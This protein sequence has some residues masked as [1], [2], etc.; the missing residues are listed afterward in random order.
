MYPVRR[1]LALLCALLVWN[2]AAGFAAGDSTEAAAESSAIQPPVAPPRHGWFG[3]FLTPYEPKRVPPV[4][5]TNSSRLEALMRAG[6][7]YLSI[8]DAIALTLENNLDIELQRYGEQ[9]AD[10]NLL[11]AQAGGFAAAAAVGVIGGPASVT[12]APASTG[13][14]GLIVLPDTQ[15]GFLVPNLDPAIVSS[16]NWA[17]QT[18]P[19]SS[20]F[21]TGTAALI[22]RQDT[23]NVAV[24]QYF[25]TGTLVSLGL[26]NNSINNN[27]ARAQFEPSTTSSLTLNFTQHLLQGF[28]PAINDRQIRIARNNREVT[29]LTFKGQVIA[30]VTAVMD[31][32][33]DLVS[34]QQV[35]KVQQDAVAADQR[36]YE[37]NQKQVEVGTLAPIEVTRAEAQIAADQQALTVAQTNVLQQETILKNALTRN[38]V[39][40]PV[41]ANA[42]IIPTDRIQV[43]DVEAI[44]PIQDSVA[45]ALSA[46]PELA[47]FRIL[48]QNQEIGIKG[49]RNELLPTLD[50]VASFANS[51]LA[52]TPVPLPASCAATPTSSQ[53]IPPN[54]YFAGGFGSAIG[55]VF[56]RNFPTYSAGFN[57]TIPLRNRAA[58]AD[59]ITGQL[60]LRQ[61]EV[62]LQKMEN[63]VRVEVQ[64]AVIALQQARAQYQAAV[65]ALR[66]QQ[67]TVD[68]EE[69]KLALGASTT[70]NVILTQRDLVTAESNLVA[71]ESAYAKANVE[72][73]RS[74][75]QT[76]NNNDISIDEAFR[77]TVSRPPSQ[78]PDVPPA[79][80]LPH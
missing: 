54:G 17:H 21:V 44:T 67:A 31:L 41:L 2:P 40:S 7:I 10:V 24:Q 78:I 70:Y 25:P 34:Y 33:W 1:Y 4:H 36:L 8:R 5:L 15:L 12:G 19:Q 48:I 26:A 38:G 57:L 49:A 46:R 6:D 22:Q 35:V 13:L 45:L 60:N 79:Q 37:N 18:T 64:N 66:L 27:N 23:S 71:A 20:N 76:L 32:Y 47:Q 3:R 80:I 74:T 77:G 72:S 73:N 42:H 50:F 59:M 62:S 63:Q 51:G 58:Q 68:A 39:A 56:N 30:T 28:G 53:C 14:Q 52:G 9:I 69:K 29:D 16:A 61:Q 11:H 55:Q 43:P 75:G 65:K